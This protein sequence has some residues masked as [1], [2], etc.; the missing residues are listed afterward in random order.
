VFFIQNAT[1][2]GSNNTTPGAEKVDESVRVELEP[3]AA[4]EQEPLGEK[5]AAKPEGDEL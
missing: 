1:T 2:A 4:R 5:E 3:G